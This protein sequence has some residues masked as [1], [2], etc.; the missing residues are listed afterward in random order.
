VPSINFV[1]KV[2]SIPQSELTGVSPNIYSLDA[3]AFRLAVLAIMD[4]VGIIYDDPFRHN[5]AVIL[6]GVTYARTIEV[7]NGYSLTF[8][9]GQYAVRIVGANTN[10]EDVTNVNQVSIRSGNS[11]GLIQVSTE[12]GGGSSLTQQQ[13]RDALK[14]APSAG[15]PANGSIDRLIR[16][17]KT[18]AE[19]NL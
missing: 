8:E 11:A 14:L 9:D 1:T 19:A 18:A 2:I 13:V 7:I 4:D 6:G 16:Q 17:T 5:T 3:N 12:G 15:S 10:F